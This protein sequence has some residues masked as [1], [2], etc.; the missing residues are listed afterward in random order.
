N[1]ILKPNQVFVEHVDDYYDEEFWGNYNIIKPEESIEDAIE[2]INKKMR[3][4]SSL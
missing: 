1:E 2:R 3:K 4:I